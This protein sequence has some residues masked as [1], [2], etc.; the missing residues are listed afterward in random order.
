MHNEHFNQSLS[1][2]RSNGN[3]DPIHDAH[4]SYSGDP[5]HDGRSNIYG[6]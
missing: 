1:D 2:V 4:C 3:N 5:F 6:M